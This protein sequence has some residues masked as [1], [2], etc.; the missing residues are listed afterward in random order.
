MATL[1][2]S[3]AGDVAIV[4]PLCWFCFLVLLCLLVALLRRALSLVLLR[5][6]LLPAA[7]W[8]RHECCELSE[9]V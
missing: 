3:G 5:L 6:L 8:Y 9:S 7:V 1:V 2:S 4:L